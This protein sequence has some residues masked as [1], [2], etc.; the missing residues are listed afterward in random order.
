MRVLVTQHMKKLKWIY[1][2]IRRIYYNLYYSLIRW[3]WNFILLTIISIELTAF[4]YLNLHY[5]STN[6]INSNDSLELILTING[7]FSAILIT[8]FFNRISWLLEIKKEDYQE[9]VGFSQKITELRRIFDRLTKYYNVWEDDKATKGLL[10]HGK[11]KHL[12]YYDFKLMSFSSYMPKDKKLIEEL[13]EDKSYKS[14][15]TDLFLGMISLVNN[16]KSNQFFSDGELYKHFEKKGIYSLKFIEKCV[17]IGY[18]SRL[19]YWFDKDYQFIQYQNLSKD[20]Q[21]YILDACVRI[22]SKYKG[23]TLNN[24]LMGEICDDMNEHYFKELYQLLL[25]LN[26][27]LKGLNLLIFIILLMSLIFG[28]LLPFFTYFI[29]EDPVSKTMATQLLIGL[30]FGLLFFFIS[31]LY[32]FIKKEITWT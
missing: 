23:A 3:D 25:R 28:V 2:I 19:G 21:T 1:N 14:G 32:G 18:A 11:Y 22:D 10:Q 4:F 8:Y 5:S 15:Q 9:A 6:K 13:N 12:D 16:R 24:K 30:N 29:L 17:E 31:N 20:T 7:L 26:N 27:G